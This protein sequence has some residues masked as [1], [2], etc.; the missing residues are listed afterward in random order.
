MT[1]N[2]SRETR[3]R[4]QAAISRLLYCPNPHATELRRA[5]GNASS[6]GRNQVRALVGKRAQPPF[7]PG[8]DLQKSDRHRGQLHF[9]EGEFMQVR[10]VI[11]RLDKD[12]E[13]LRSIIGQCSWA[14][15]HSIFN[16][17]LLT[18]EGDPG[19]QRRRREPLRS[20]SIYFR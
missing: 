19:R 18:N 1:P 17:D 7:Y 13:K 14:R 12:Q 5:K 8:A 11:V 2:V 6:N 16:D 4:V 20:R 9:L 3:T 15:P 10:R